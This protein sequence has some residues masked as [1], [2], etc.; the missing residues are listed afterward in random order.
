M[1]NKLKGIALMLFGV[2]VA[3]GAV[4]EIVYLWLIGLFLG[5]CGLV[6][7]FRE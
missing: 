3:I 4:F 6:L 5:G 7:I 1:D 2:I